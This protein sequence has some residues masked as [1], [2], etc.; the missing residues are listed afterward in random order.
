M[1]N[2]TTYSR[3]D[4]IKEHG[5][6]KVLFAENLCYAILFNDA[7]I[8]YY[9]DKA[10]DYLKEVCQAAGGDEDLLILTGQKQEEM[11][12]W[13]EKTGDSIDVYKLNGVIIYVVSH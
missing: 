9:W 8:V 3:E 10:P 1:Y 13:V 5:H 2:S 6:L 11:P 12:Y 7:F 4:L